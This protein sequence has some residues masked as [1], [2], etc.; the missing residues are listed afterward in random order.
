MCSTSITKGCCYQKD[1]NLRH[2]RGTKK[3]K[4]KPEV[5]NKDPTFLESVHLLKEEIMKVMDTKFSYIMSQIST[6]QQSPVTRYQP[7]APQQQQ[8][9]PIL[10]GFLPVPPPINKTMKQMEIPPLMQMYIPPPKNLQQ[11]PRFHPLKNLQD[12]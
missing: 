8:P 12:F 2:V 4:P 1:C 6:N 9:T 11:P 10:P 7:M 5:T 3:E